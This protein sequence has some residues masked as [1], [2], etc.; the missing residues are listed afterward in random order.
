MFDKYIN[1]TYKL[2]KLLF[3]NN[4][5]YTNNMNIKELPINVE[6]KAVKPSSREMKEYIFT[7]FPTFKFGYSE[8]IQKVK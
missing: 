3:Y 8:L 6:M 1:C 7:N 5:E 2:T 4:G